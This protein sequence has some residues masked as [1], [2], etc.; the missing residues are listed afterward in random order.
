MIDEINITTNTMV[1]TNMDFSRPRRL[2]YNSP[3]LPNPA[4][5]EAPRCCSK[6]KMIDKNA[7]MKI[8]V[9]RKFPICINNSY[10]T[11]LAYFF[12]SVKNDM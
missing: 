10:E 8:T 2:V 12:F 3:E 5:R 7:E 6:I 11:I 1:V 4:P 9:S